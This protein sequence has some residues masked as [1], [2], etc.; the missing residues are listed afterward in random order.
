MPAGNDL[1]RCSPLAPKLQL[2][3]EFVCE[4][5][6]RRCADRLS[7]EPLVIATPR[8]R[9]SQTRACRS[10]SFGT[11]SEQLGPLGPEG[12][13]GPPGE[14]TEAALAAAIDGT[15]SNSNLVDTLDTPD[16]SNEELR[17]KLNELLLALRR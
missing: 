10:R 5:P 11:R 12:P 9:A 2:G 4:A 1:R 17:L 8:S 7:R 13:Q 6:L 16:P 14:V 15:S 3:S